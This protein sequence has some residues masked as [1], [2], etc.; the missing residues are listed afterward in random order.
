MAK[1]ETFA[2]DLDR[3]PPRTVSASKLDRN[4]AKCYPLR[5]G[6]LAHMNLNQSD[7][8]WYLEIPAPPAGIA[9][10]GSIGGV[11]QWILTEDC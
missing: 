10:L 5:R 7:D 1:L 3:D 8:G 2:D 11:V 6:L 9:V 4:F